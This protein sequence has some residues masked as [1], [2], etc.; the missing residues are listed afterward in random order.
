MRPNGNIYKY[1]AVYVDDLAFAVREPQSL[2]ESLRKKNGF[3]FKGTGPLNF[4]LGADFDRDEEGTLCM[5][6][7]NMLNVW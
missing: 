6:L 5:H 1:I 2:V 4:H 3:Q 7:A